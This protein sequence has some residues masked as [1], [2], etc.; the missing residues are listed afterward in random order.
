V[1]K[2]RARRTIGEHLETEPNEQRER[3]P[4]L[5]QPVENVAPRSL[6]DQKHEK[7]E[8]EVHRR[9][10]ALRHDKEGHHDGAVQHLRRVEHEQ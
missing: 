1:P 10:P 2:V 7:V 9:E 5:R 8:A 6:G 3:Y 4:S